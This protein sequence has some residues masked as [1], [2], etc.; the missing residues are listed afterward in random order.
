MVTEVPEFKSSSSPYHSYRNL[1]LIGDAAASIAPASGDGLAM[2][3]TSGVMAADFAIK[4]EDKSYQ[5]H[6]EKK[7]RKRLR[8]AKGLH[9]IM[10]YPS[11]SKIT[12]STCS[13]YP[14]LFN[15]LFRRTR[16]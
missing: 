1:F 3:V 11:I 7:F 12:L 2:A 13:R 15:Y 5:H 8:W 14:E 16:K 4:G 9:K 6:W 10:F